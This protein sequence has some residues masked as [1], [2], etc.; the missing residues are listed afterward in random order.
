MGMTVKLYAPK[1]S[2]RGSLIARFLAKHHVQHE[3]IRP[4]DLPVRKGLFRF[5]EVP[6]IEIDGSFY[7]DPNEDALKKILQVEPD[8]SQF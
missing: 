2:S 7:I 4:E 3:L 5:G 8:S 1:K 6:M